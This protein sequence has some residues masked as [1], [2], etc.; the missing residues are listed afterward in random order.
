MPMTSS[1]VTTTTDPDRILS[2][3]SS[4]VLAIKR[5]S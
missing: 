2:L 4:R 1:A 5:T 3:I